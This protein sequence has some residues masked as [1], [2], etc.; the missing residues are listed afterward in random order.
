ME[1]QGNTEQKSDASHISGTSVFGHETTVR[2]R[3]TSPKKLQKFLHLGCLNSAG[4]N[5][6]EY[7][8]LSLG[9]ALS[10]RAHL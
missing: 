5:V 9:D 8:A 1:K 7:S 6:V 3:I 4:L 10:A 2:L